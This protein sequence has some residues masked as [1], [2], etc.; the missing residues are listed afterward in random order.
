MIIFR[1]L[2]SLEYTIA[3]QNINEKGQTYLYNDGKMYLVR[4][5]NG[6]TKLV[7]NRVLQNDLTSNRFGKTYDCAILDKWGYR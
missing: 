5:A 4:I 7:C 3:K 2:S 1:D 6:K